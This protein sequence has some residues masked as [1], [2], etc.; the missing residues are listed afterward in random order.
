MKLNLK[1][2]VNMLMSK[3]KLKRCKNKLNKCKK[4]RR[5]C[6]NSRQSCPRLTM[7]KLEQNSSS[8][9]NQT[10]KLHNRRN[11]KQ[12]QYLYLKKNRN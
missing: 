2:M 9:F 5:Q 6:K 4:K 12:S 7:R 1:R 10:Y 11:L 8:S 3:L